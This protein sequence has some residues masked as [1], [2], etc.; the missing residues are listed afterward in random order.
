MTLVVARA[1]VG[2]HEHEPVLRE[3]RAEGVEERGV[4]LVVARDAR[5]TT[6]PSERAAR[7][8]NLGVVACDAG[9]VRPGVTTT[10]RLHGSSASADERRIAPRT[11]T[12]GER[13][14]DD[15][16]VA[17]VHSRCISAS[18]TT[19]RLPKETRVR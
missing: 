3:S 13:R 1:L 10:T 2:N 8:K 17:C 5:A 9:R 15:C 11:V 19:R 18:R 14:D 16:R 4:P 7:R 6:V 12:P